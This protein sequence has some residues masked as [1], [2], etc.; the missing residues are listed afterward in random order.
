[1]TKKELEKRIEILEEELEAAYEDMEI[2]ELDKT[3]RK[4]I[5]QTMVI[6]NAFK[7]EGLSTSE[8]IDITKALVEASS[9]L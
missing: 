2:A 9:R 5:K 4:A 1:M 7:T 3:T 6:V 8:A